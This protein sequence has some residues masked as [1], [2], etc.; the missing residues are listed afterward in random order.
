MIYLGIYIAIG[1]WIVIAIIFGFLEA[2]L[3]NFDTEYE[4]VFKR[5]TG[6]GIHIAFTV[7]RIIFAAPIVGVIYYYFDWIEAMNLS[8]LMIFCF[9]FFHDGAYY[10]FRKRLSYGKIYPVGWRDRS[11]T[12][13]AF[14][15]LGYY[16]RTMLFVSGILLFLPF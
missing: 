15:S 11:T 5:E 8:L 14:F 7:V 4:T 10:Q 9:P 16:Q 1:L 2:K 3:F 12:T 13:S 6:V